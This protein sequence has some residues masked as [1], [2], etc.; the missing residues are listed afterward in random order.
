[1]PNNALQTNWTRVQTRIRLRLHLTWAV[2]V[3]GWL[4]DGAG[5]RASACFG[6]EPAE[7][8]LFLHKLNLL[9]KTKVTLIIAE[10]I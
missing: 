3:G 5:Q 4:R 8:L 10:K 1:M 6:G 7:L 9:K 2:A